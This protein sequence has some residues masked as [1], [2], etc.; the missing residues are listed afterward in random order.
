MVQASENKWPESEMSC[1]FYSDECLFVLILTDI[2]SLNTPLWIPF[3]AQLP[4]VTQRM[5]SLEVQ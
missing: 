3:S 2:K 1:I 5:V 4:M